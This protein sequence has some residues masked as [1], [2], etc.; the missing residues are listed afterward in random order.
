MVA[1]AV[2]LN[3]WLVLF[4]LLIFILALM[5]VT[6]FKR[7][8][9][10][11]VM[12]GHFETLRRVCWWLF[13]KK[14]RDTNVFDD[15]ILLCILFFIFCMALDYPLRVPGEFGTKIIRTADAVFAIIFITEMAIKLVA[16]GLIWERAPTS[17]IAGIFW[18]ALLSA[19]LI[20]GPGGGGFLKTLRI[21]RAPR[22]LRVISRNP[23]LKMV[24]QIIFAPL[25]ALMTLI[26]VLAVYE[27]PMRD[28][29]QWLFAPFFV[30]YIFMS[31]MF[32][33]NLSAGVIVERFFE[34]KKAYAA[35]R[36]RRR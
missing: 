16:I 30:T 28:N 10:Y 32:L 5:F 18:M 26:I 29:R 19:V 6:F 8:L 34:E 12:D 2:S 11:A 33:L 36:G 24:V 35:M 4:F 31:F 17:G 21:L 3:Y 9:H 23:N 7:Q 15:V 27:E 14:V 22:P 25:P 1:M 13:K 20:S